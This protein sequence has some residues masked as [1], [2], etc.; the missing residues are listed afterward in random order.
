MTKH[1]FTRRKYLKNG[2]VAILGLGVAGCTSQF[3]SSDNVETQTKSPKPTQTPIQTSVSTDTDNSVEAT[4][5][6]TST[7]RPIDLTHF[8]GISGQTYPPD[9]DGS[10]HRQFEWEAVGSSWSYQVNI[11]KSRGEYYTKRFRRSDYDIYVTDPYDDGYIKG[12]ADEFERVGNEYDLTQREV[13]DLAVAFVHAMNYTKDNVTSPYDQYK[14]YPL[15]TLIER[16]GDCEDSTILLA[17]ILRQMGYGCVLLG[18]FDAEPAHMALG[19]KGD[20]SVRGTYY[21]YQGDRYYFVETTGDGWKIGEMPDF[22][23]STDAEII[24][25][26]PHP[27]LVYDFETSVRLGE[28]VNLN[29][30]VWNYGE[31]SGSQTSFIA[32]FEDRSGEV[33]AADE[34]RIGPIA[35][36]EQKTVSL[37]LFPP[38]N[39]ELRLNA[40]VVIQNSLHDI[41]RSGW[42]E[43]V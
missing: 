25:I 17:A 34:I 37:E 18:L 28:G 14:Y 35:N 23:G 5:T 42:R 3:D 2:S 43:P 16:G 20:E 7:E 41:A 36:E 22:D 13:V 6:E 39:R 9:I 1:R 8:N 11:S 12:I 26:D 38:D 30:N 27:V 40:A 19:V 21:T 24:E 4:P 29:A 33:V 31:K 32:E 10:H 15:E